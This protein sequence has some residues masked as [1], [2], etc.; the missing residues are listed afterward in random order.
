M[1]C[2]QCQYEN[3]AGAIRCAK[4]DSSLDLSGETATSSGTTATGAGATVTSGAG[5]SGVTEDWSKPAAPAGVYG[6][7]Q[8]LVPGT[9]LGGRYE[10]LELLGEG[11]MGAVYKARDRELDRFV[12]LKVIRPELANQQEVLRRFKQELILARQVTHKSVIRIFDLGEAEGIKF[13]SMDYIEGQDLRSLLRQKGRLAPE[14]A[15]AIIAQVCQAL[16]AAHAE[17]VVHRDLKPQNIMLDSQGRATVMDFGIARSMELT[18]MTQTGALLGTPDYMSPEQARGQE[19]DARSDLFTLGII[20]YEL[21]TGKTPY[22]ADTVLGTLL[23]RTQ[24]RA[25]PPIELDPDLPRYLS[26]VAVR[27]LEIDPRLRYQKASEILAD[28]EAQRK[29]RNTTLLLR[30]PRFRTV[31]ELSTKWIGPALAALVLLLAVVVFRGKI[32]G[33]VAKPKPATPAVS[34]AILPFRNTSGDP[35]LDWLGPSLAEMLNTDVGQSAYLQTVS[36]SRVSQILH[37]LRIAPDS[38]IDPDTLRRIGEFTSADRLLWGQFAKFGDQIRIDVTLR[39]LKQQRTFP[40]KATAPNEKDLPRAVEQLA[41]EVQKSLALP[42]DIIKELQARAL[43]PST[44]SVQA[45]RYYNEG[46]QLA[47]QG[48]VLDAQKSFQAATRE[49]QNFALAYAK[50][51]QADA[52][53]GYG[54]EAEQAARKAVD[55]SEKLPPQ[56]KYLIAAIHA[57]TVNDNQKAIEAYENLAKALPEDSDVQLALAGLYQ[58]AGSSDKAR[59]CYG[60]LLSRDPKY[61]E[62]LIGMCGVE[63]MAGNPQA[64]ID[65]L[66]RALALAIELGNDEE[67]STILYEFG[68]IYNQL[69]KPEESLRNY[70]QALEIERRLG[71]KED[72]A[73]TFKGM[74]QVQDPLG[75][76]DEAL[77]SLEAALRLLR[78]IGDKAGVGDTLIDLSNF[79]EAHAQNDQALGLLKESLQIQREV[80]NQTYEALCLNNIG[81]NYADKGQYDDALTYLNQALGLREKLKDPVGVAD[82]NYQMADVLAK[83]GQFDQAL[84]HYLTALEV[85]RRVNDKRREAYTSYGL[86]NVFEQQGRLGAALN[87]KAEALKAIREV[88]DRIGMAEMVGGY[89]DSLNLLGRSEE[90]QKSLEEALA[91]AREVKNQ[92]LI[93]QSLN[94]QGDSFF[95]RGDLKG[96]KGRYQQALQAAGRTTDRRLVLISK[97][98]LAKVAVKEGRSRAAVS[99]L[100]GLAG[101]ADALGLKYVSVECSVYVGEALVNAKD[102]S[103]A[104]QELDRALARS[105]K[106]GLEAL[107]A[108]SQHLLATALRLTGNGAEA[109]RHYAD[110]HRILDE[111]SAEAKS[112]TLLKR[113]DLG[114][115]YAESAKWSR[116]ATP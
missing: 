110:A 47:H 90:A 26:D 5:A 70:Q 44:Q 78:E 34:L 14:E 40:L 75:K 88:Q 59:E 20:L 83:V 108:K 80:G 109:S 71:K 91:V 19:V 94:F 101:Q 106:L 16:E 112:D 107:Q 24:E 65:Y 86:G 74:A 27:C 66:N 54:S 69:S 48:K 95:Y 31:E 15:T 115:I 17:G 57:R 96:A 84:K 104:G 92:A 6:F 114:P 43:K 38:N 81:A 9:V 82:S 21:L 36:S 55:L 113:A 42:A 89:A 29:P 79:Y 7:A 76:P 10:I 35:S 8:A 56:E 64:G 77:K 32:F 87:A 46:V 11:G 13:I 62:A 103:Q 3:P 49:D 25:R 39:D 99:E 61:V 97:F 58:A 41:A 1:Q 33:P 73:Q 105:E 2:P 4:C 100:R 23:K 18:G 72:I 51:G 53:L 67:K 93:G 22:R 68:V 30:L 102:Y 52:N 116:S 37:D 50:L 28:L 63:V 98:N 60:K 85:W 12:A 45:L 111:M